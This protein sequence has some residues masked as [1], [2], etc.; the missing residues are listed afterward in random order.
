MNNKM[1]LFCIT[2]GLSIGLNFSFTATAFNGVCYD[3][4]RDAYWLC[5]GDPSSSEC[6]AAQYYC[7]MCTD[8]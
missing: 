2:V 3:A 8:E 4:C 5:G 7:D 1:K 6:A